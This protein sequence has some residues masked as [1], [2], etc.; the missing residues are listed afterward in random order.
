[1]S[2]HG[3]DLKVLEAFCQRIGH[4]LSSRQIEAFRGYRDALYEANRVMNLTRVPFDQ[5]EVRHFVDS[6]LFVD[7]VPQSA[8]VLDVGTGPGLPAWPI[9]CARPDALVDALDSSGKML[10]FL[11][12][13]VLPNLRCL[14]GRAEELRLVE[15]YD[16]VTGRAL[17]P[18]A[19][20][21]EL[22]AAACRVGGI[23]VPMRT[24]S[25][26]ELVRSFAG[27]GLG[28]K[29]ESIERRVLPGTDV[30]RLLPVF[31]KVARTDPRFPRGWAD[32]KRRPLD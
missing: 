5:C 27:G 2:G 3:G 18:L 28:L 17:A 23:V 8:S 7:L 14:L 30:V 26:E 19:I 20:Q 6:L 25:E 11:Q 1:M 16:V 9:A 21:L 13:L 4:P 10:G 31:R 24:P 32:I 22:S 29:L 15:A 12:R